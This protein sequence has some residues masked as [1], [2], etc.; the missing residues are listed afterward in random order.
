MSQLGGNDRKLT[1]KEIADLAR[2]LTTTLDVE[3][4]KEF[5]H[6]ST[7]DELFVSYVTENLPLEQMILELLIQLERLG[8]TADFLACVYVNRPG[9]K[10]VRAAIVEFFPEAV[11]ISD[12]K[13]NP[14]A[15]GLG[16][17]VGG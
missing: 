3:D 6:A 10:S 15:K 14:G 4:L 5:V 2:L 11:S 16:D 9:K 8:K 7:G 1:G 17:A 12:R 13:I